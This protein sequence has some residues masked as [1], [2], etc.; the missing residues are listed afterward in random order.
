MITEKT[1]RGIAIAHHEI[2]VARDLLGKIEEGER[3][4]AEPDLRDV[5][6]RTRGLQLGVPQGET[7]HRLY[8]VSYSAAKLVLADHI[9]QQE[10]VIARLSALAVEEAQGTAPSEAPPAA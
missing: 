8:T 10:A 5:Y 4:N 7:A 3:A 1:A 2:R 6:G 9:A